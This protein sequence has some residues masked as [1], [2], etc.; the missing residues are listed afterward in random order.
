MSYTN[1]RSYVAIIIAI[2]FFLQGA[3]YAHDSSVPSALA[4]L[5]REKPTVLITGSNR[6]IGFAFVKHYSKNGWNVIA[7]CRNPNKA[8][9]LQLLRN[10]S[11]NI[12]IEEMDVT[13]F[14]EINTLAQK[15]QGYP[16]DVL[17]NNAG[18]LGNVPK[19]SFG[20][21][22]YD[23]FQTV[24]A[25]NAFGPLKVAEAFADSVAIS[26]QKKIV[27]MTSGLGSFAI[28]GNFDRF[29]FYKMSKSAINMG[30]LTMNAS[31]KSKGII[32]ALISPGMVDTKLLDE[33]GYQGRN[34]I[35]PEESVAGLVKIIAEISLDTMKK[36]R[37]RPTNFDEK[38]LPW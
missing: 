32:A 31:L 11:T 35:S 5:D 20:N 17:V 34:K 8:D 36:T 16:I 1:F 18:I 24:M 9:D 27:T 19:Q 4:S 22:D 25:V 6:G 7:T 15:Y 21:L 13:D 3:T 38:I 28:M 26:N 37:G 23:L 33:S 2:F 29:F 10:N 14:E 12:F 30:V